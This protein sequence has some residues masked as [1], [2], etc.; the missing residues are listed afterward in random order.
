MP[1]EYYDNSSS[2]AKTAA[3]WKPADYP[4]K[5]CQEWK[6]NISIDLLFGFTRNVPLY[7]LLLIFW[8]LSVLVIVATM[9]TW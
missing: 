6:K 3:P 2:R 8:L 9:V 5:I 1:S 4:S 7:T